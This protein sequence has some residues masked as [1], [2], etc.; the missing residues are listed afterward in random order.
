M[1]CRV[2]AVEPAVQLIYSRASSSGHR[3]FLSWPSKGPVMTKA[4]T[5]LRPTAFPLTI[6]RLLV[7]PD[8]YLRPQLLTR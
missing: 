4:T 5:A 3:R 1:C 8:F 7:P 6:T 2:H